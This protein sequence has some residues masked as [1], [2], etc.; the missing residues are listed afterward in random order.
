MDITADSG[1]N[2]G[3]YATLNPLQNGGL[4]LSNGNLD[5]A[6]VQQVGLTTTGTI[7]ISSGKY[8]FEYTASTAYDNHM[9][10]CSYIRCYIIYLSR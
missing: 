3:N 7:G 1:N 2:P 9:I 6:K 10:G 5:V 8:Y 4:T